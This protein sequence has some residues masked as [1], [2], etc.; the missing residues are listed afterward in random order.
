M[1]RRIALASIVHLAPWP[2]GV[3]GVLAL[4]VIVW[5]LAAGG[6]LRWALPAGMSTIGAG[7]LILAFIFWLSFVLVAVHTDRRL[8]STLRVAEVRD[9]YRAANAATVGMAA[10]PALFFFAFTL[11]LYL[12]HLLLGGDWN[13]WRAM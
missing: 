13:L 5:A 2:C 10:A 8:D 11:P 12:M 7:W 1:S 6:D 9:H 3:G 4:T